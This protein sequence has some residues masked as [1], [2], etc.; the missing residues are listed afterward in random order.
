MPHKVKFLLE[1]ANC[2]NEPLHLVNSEMKTGGFHNPAPYK[3]MAGHK[4]SFCGHTASYVAGVSGS[5]AYRIGKSAKVFVVAFNCPRFTGSNTLALQFNQWDQ[6]KID[7][8]PPNGMYDKINV[9]GPWK[10]AFIKGG[11]G[12]PLEVTDE[13]L[14]DE[15][16]EYELGGGMGVFSATE[17]KVSLI[18][19]DDNK[20]ATT[21]KSGFGVKETKEIQEVKKHEH[22]HVHCKLL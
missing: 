5:V 16:H 14:C 3:I 11:S 17:I 6:S 13:A 8:M 21:L 2:T 12:K 15:G 22:V 1:I 18:P 7:S 4:E 9:D 10:K 19:K 20:I